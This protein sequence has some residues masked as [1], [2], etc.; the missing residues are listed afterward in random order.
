MD[1][2]KIYI[3]FENKKLHEIEPVS[4][5][6]I[7]HPSKKFDFYMLSYNDLL[8]Q[9]N[10]CLTT[11]V[12]DGKDFFNMPLNV[13]N[14]KINILLLNSHIEDTCILPSNISFGRVLMVDSLIKNISEKPNLKVKLDI[15]KDNNEYY[16]SCDDFKKYFK[17]KYPD[18][19]GTIGYVVINDIDLVDVKYLNSNINIEFNMQPKQFTSG[20]YI[21]H[22]VN[23]KFVKQ[24]EVDK[25]NYVDADLLKK[26]HNQIGSK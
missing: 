16:I 1:N 6:K 25:K 26:I 10:N 15:I 5:M 2:E 7:Y 22:F 11:L 9:K 18:F 8:T 12:S 14:E 20:T 21:Y 19:N 23:G 4:L 24:S 3:E 17:D 13:F